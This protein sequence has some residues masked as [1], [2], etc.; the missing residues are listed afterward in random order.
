MKHL[1]IVI[2]FLVSTG[3]Y[4][5][6]S[7]S[8]EVDTNRWQ[9]DVF[10]SLIEDYRQLS[11]IYPE[12]IIARAEVDST[13][14][15][16]FIG[17]QLESNHRLYRIHVDNCHEDSQDANHFSGSCPD[18]KSIIFI[19]K[20]TDTIQFPF[21]FE[22]EMFCDIKSSNS[23]AIA[24]IQIDSLKEEMRYAFSEFRSE[25]NRKLNTK[26]WFTT[27]QEFGESLNEPLAELYIYSY[28]S[29][30]SSEFYDYYMNDLEGSNYYNELQQR[31]SANYPETTYTQKYITELE[32][33]QYSV[34][35][36]Q[37]G[38]NWH[39]LIYAAL[40][41]S[42]LLN[43]VFIINQQKAKLERRTN[44]KEKL[45]QQEKKILDLL[46]TDASNK[47]IAEQLFVSLSTIKTHVNNIYKKYNVQSRESL[48]DLFIK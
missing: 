23:K 10:L 38:F 11:G 47:D 21:T 34:S 3:L 14:R 2:A 29:D 20:N 13:G 19:A 42:L 45:T 18:S 25:A 22:N 43:V 44:L 7:F 24:L 28:I 6:F 48:K 15:F 33:D 16:E 12:Q 36:K 1:A 30:R 27:L 5:Q 8:G 40:A 46:L 41:I 31:L 9:S 35:K 26:K 37:E 32:A 39:Y 4:A 17:N